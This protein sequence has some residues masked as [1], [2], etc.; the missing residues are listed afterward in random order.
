MRMPV[1]VPEKAQQES[2][3]QMPE[4]PLDALKIYGTWCAQAQS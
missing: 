3:M 4:H 1:A 2:N